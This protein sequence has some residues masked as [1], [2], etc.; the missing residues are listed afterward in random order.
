MGTSAV[1]VLQGGWMNSIRRTDTSEGS[2]VKVV[3][4]AG[5]K[6]VVLATAQQE[7][8]GA[9]L[10][11]NTLYWFESQE[12]ALHSL[13]RLRMARPLLRGPQGVVVHILKLGKVDQFSRKINLA[14]H[15]TPQIAFSFQYAPASRQFMP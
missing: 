1:S 8:A 12:A 11:T 14:P 9:I 10:V 5:R 13:L 7:V 2:A 15:T 4:D 3:E 6:Y